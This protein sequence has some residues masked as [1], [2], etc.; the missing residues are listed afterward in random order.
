MLP[1]RLT[2]FSMLSRLH[3]GSFLVFSATQN[4]ESSTLPIPCVCLTLQVKKMHCARRNQEVVKSEQTQRNSR[5]NKHWLLLNKQ[6]RLPTHGP[7]ST[8]N[9]KRENLDLRELLGSKTFLTGFRYK[10][11]SIWPGSSPT[12]DNQPLQS[13]TWTTS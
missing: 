11:H 7:H 2:N 12:H 1:P 3:L 9:Q 10:G 13:Q 5:S 6:A 4:H 8:K